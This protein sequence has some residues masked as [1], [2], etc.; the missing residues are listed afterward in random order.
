MNRNN[1]CERLIGAARE[2][3]PHYEAALHSV[4]NG[5]WD[6]MLIDIR[7][8]RI[9]KEEGRRIVESMRPL[10]G[11]FLADEMS[12]QVDKGGYR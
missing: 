5:A 12:N 1:F 3:S 9:T 11:D 6:E 8:G 2:Q 10:T 4:V 7:R